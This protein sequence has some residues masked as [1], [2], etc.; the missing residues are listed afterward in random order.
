MTAY[1]HKMIHMEMKAG[2]NPCC[3]QTFWGAHNQV[4]IFSAKAKSVHCLQAHQEQGSAIWGQCLLICSCSQQWTSGVLLFTASG[5][6]PTVKPIFTKSTKAWHRVLDGKTSHSS[7]RFHSLGMFAL[8]FTSGEI[9]IWKS[10]RKCKI[11]CVD[12]QRKDAFWRDS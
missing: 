9:L 1:S 5:K 7:S 10:R 4:W 12:Y 3:S 6:L 8:F 11:L 2:R